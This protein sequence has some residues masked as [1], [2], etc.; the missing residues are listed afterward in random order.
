VLVGVEVVGR[1]EG[2]AVGSAE[3]VEVVGAG[4][5]PEG[6]AVGSKE[7]A[8]LGSAERCPDKIISKENT[9]LAKRHIA[10]M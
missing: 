6:S 1:W 4:E 5:G 2:G 7:G 10:Y 8:G 3:G 9:L